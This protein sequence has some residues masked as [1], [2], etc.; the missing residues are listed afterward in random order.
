VLLAVLQLTALVAS[1][2]YFRYKS[3]QEGAIRL[4]EDD[5]SEEGQVH[6]HRNANEGDFAIQGGGRGPREIET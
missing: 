5:E 4:P 2:L 1:I 3:K 6:R